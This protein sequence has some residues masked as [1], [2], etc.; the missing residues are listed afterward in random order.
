M[1]TFSANGISSAAKEVLGQLFLDGPVWDGNISSKVGRGELVA[2]G[3]A[4]HA[5][6][7][8]FLTSEG[9]RIAVEWQHDDVALHRSHFNMRWQ[10]KAYGR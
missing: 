7:F 5:H 9:V 10:K 1:S 8:A 4:E 3:L 6:G 2:A